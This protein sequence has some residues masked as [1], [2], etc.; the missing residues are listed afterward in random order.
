MPSPLNL[1]PDD[2]QVNLSQVRLSL[3][4]DNYRDTLIV[5]GRMSTA[6][7]WY[8]PL[9]FNRI[10]TLL[11]LYNEFPQLTPLAHTAGFFLVF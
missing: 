9:G 1:Y 4:V 11:I 8:L 6:T 2:V 7:G 5:S 10:P 3:S